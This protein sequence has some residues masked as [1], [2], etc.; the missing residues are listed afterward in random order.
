MAQSRKEVKMQKAELKRRMDEL[1]A[2]RSK[3]ECAYSA[4]NNVTDPSIMD[5]CIF[6][7]SALKSRYN[8]AV[9]G[10]REMI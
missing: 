1:D 2:I 4:F 10:I 8:Y 9:K 7:I 5:A 3:L 6:E